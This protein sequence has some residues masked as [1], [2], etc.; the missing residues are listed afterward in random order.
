MLSQNFLTPEQLDLTQEQRDALMKVLG[1]LERGE[2]QHRAVT[3]A[4]H[5]DHVGGLRYFN[6]TEWS[7]GTVACIG[8]WAEHVGGVSMHYN[9]NIEL[10]MLFFPHAIPRPWGAITTEQAAAA[11]RNY[12]T[13]GRA[14]WRSVMERR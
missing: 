6:M 4:R 11:L 5:R 10:H 3:V 14:D 12:L 7:C 8:G 1:M 2:I 13:T 9:R